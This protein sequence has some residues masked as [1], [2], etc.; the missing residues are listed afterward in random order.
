MIAAYERSMNVACM[1]HD[2]ART[3]ST[4]DIRGLLAVGAEDSGIEISFSRRRGGG[5]VTELAK[6]AM[7]GKHVFSLGCLIILREEQERK[8]K[9]WKRVLVGELLH[10]TSAGT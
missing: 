7:E 5:R 1:P 10:P 3:S 4:V 9:I 8:W 2:R 6:R